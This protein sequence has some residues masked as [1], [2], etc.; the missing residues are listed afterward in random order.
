MVMQAPCGEQFMKTKCYRLHNY[1]IKSQNSKNCLQWTFNRSMPSIYIHTVAI[2]FCM[3]NKRHP[4]IIVPLYTVLPS[5]PLTPLLLL[6][7]PFMIS[8][9]HASFTHNFTTHSHSPTHFICILFTLSMCNYVV[10]SS[11]LLP[12][13]PLLTCSSLSW[14]LHLLHIC[15]WS[16]LINNLTSEFP[17]VTGPL[18]QNLCSNGGTC[19][20][21]GTC[22]CAAGFTGPSCN[23]DL[24]HHDGFFM[25]HLLILMQHLKRDICTDL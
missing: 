6:F 12:V 1:G 20:S 24:C 10:S 11:L 22:V 14:L 23:A 15:P 17:P 19:G 7:T 5:L 25:I 9:L 2:H 16:Q 3:H 18:C 13:L 4:F 8:F 21:S